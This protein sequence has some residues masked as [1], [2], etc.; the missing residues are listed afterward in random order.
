M[1]IDLKAGATEPVDGKPQEAHVL[2]HAAAEGNPFKAG[3]LTKSTAGP[4]CPAF[5]DSGA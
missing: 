3:P 4:G 2:K 1:R 5:E